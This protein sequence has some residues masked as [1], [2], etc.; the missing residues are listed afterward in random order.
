MNQVIEGIAWIAEQKKRCHFF[1]FFLVNIPYKSEKVDVAV[2]HVN[3]G[4]R[5]SKTKEETKEK[6]HGKIL[7]L[8][9]KDRIR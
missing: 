3:T 2:C 1:F 5:K 7:L 4:G 9:F 8:C 6:N